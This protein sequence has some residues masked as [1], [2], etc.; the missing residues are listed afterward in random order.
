MSA[1]MKSTKSFI[2]HFS[3]LNEHQFENVDLAI[4]EKFICGHDD[5]KFDSDNS[6]V[7]TKDAR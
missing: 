4:C 1:R 3:V 6:F 7:A 5:A 2:K